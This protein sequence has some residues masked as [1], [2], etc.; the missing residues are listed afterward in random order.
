M[1]EAAFDTMQQLADSRAQCER[2]QRE[3]DEAKGRN[4]M[5]LA[6]LKDGLAIPAFTSRENQHAHHPLH[7]WKRRVHEAFPHLSC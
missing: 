6:L 1:N 3:L 5:A 2:L 4:I 7:G